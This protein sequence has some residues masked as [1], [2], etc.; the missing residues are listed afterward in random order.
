ME[1]TVVVW[2]VRWKEW[3]II[4]GDACREVNNVSSHSPESEPCMCAGNTYSQTLRPP[5]LLYD[6]RR[7]E[8]ERLK[9][10]LVL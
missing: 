10:Q 7:H 9:G 1:G 8:R 5:H 3:L 4:N 2:K 6:D